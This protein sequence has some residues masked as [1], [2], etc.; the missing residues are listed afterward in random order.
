MTE[1]DVQILLSNDPISRKKTLRSIANTGFLNVWEGAVRSGKTVYALVAFCLYAV[2]S[3]EKVFLLSGRTLP[4]IE[5]NAIMGDY[6]ILSL[7]PGSRYGKVGNSAAITFSVKDSNG[8]IVKKTIY[9]SGAAD[10]KS[11]MALRGNTY[12]GWFADEINMHDQ[13]FVEEAFNRTVK[14]ADRKHFW[15]LNPDNPN[16]WIYKDYLDRYDAMGKKERKELG[17]YHWWHYTPTDNP[18]LTPQMIKAMELQYPP[19]SYLYRRYILGERCMAEGLIYPKITRAM[20]R[21][22]ADMVGTDIRYCAIDFGAAH[23]TCMLFGGMFRGNKLDWRIVAEYYDENSDKT[24][25]DHYAGYLDM[26]NKLGI[27]PNKVIIA[28][29][30]AAKVLRQEFLKHNLNVIKAKNDVLPGIEYTRNVLYNGTLL[31]SES[32]KHTD[33]QF[34]TYSWDEKASERGDE[35]PIKQNDDCMDTLRYFAF[36]F[37]KPITRT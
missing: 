7:I 12:A 32:C 29:D 9:V 25:Y 37:M 15:S 2:R 8:H 19:E 16:A 26:C 35:K 20:F 34:G 13:R 24:T 11:Y 33:Q 30:P 3:K 31:L 14:S 1:E 5:K 17:G 22:D 21:P 36:T 10:I 27:E 23:A 28:I 4:T 6:G 18:S